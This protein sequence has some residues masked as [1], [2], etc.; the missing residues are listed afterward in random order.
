MS[1]EPTMTDPKSDYETE[2]RDDLFDE[3]VPRPQPTLTVAELLRQLIVAPEQVAPAEW[4]LFSDLSRADVALVRRHWN[5]I[6]LPVRFQLL[7]RLVRS[8]DE[9]L[10]VDL[11]AL[12]AILLGDSD[13]GLRRRALELLDEGEPDASL[14]GPILQRL[15]QD[16]SDEVR[17]AAAAALGHYVL[18]GELGE[19][20]TALAMRIENALLAVLADHQQPL[21]V[22]C[23]ALESIAYSEENGVRQLIEDAYYS[24]W[25]PLRVSAL[26]AMGNSV[27]IRWRRLVRA[28]L[29]NPDPAM[30]AAAARTC[31]EL[32]AK[33]ALSTLLDLLEDDE[34]PVRLSVIFALGRLGGKQARQALEQ[35]AAS[36]RVEASAAEL[37]LEE[38]LFY[39]G[40]DAVRISLYDEAEDEDVLD[41]LDP[42]DSWEDDEDL[43]EYR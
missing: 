39:T 17:A 20:E 1:K 7:E 14:A 3:E 15:Q 19:L 29:R 6:A 21:A 33:A 40:A 37:A 8:A 38:M 16:S 18:A 23:K 2:E 27:D 25:E 5:Q 35:L 24:G 30:R 32:E 11:T 36:D 42:W 26:V 9:F 4:F 12:L 22:R 31:G 13:S 34:E 28:E 10:D 43:G 41:D